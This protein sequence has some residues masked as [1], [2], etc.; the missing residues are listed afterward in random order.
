MADAHMC[1]AKDK[2]EWPTQRR[3]DKS[4]AWVHLRQGQRL[5]KERDSGKRKFDEMSATE[6][7]LVEDY[8]SDRL[9][10]RYKETKIEKLPPFRGKILPLLIS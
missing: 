4:K 1:A 7:Q 5:A 6:Q 8:D 9:K 10:K 2:K 3:R